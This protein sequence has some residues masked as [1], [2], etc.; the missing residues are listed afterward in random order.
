MRRQPSHGGGHWFESSSAHQPSLIARY[1][2]SYGCTMNR[3][4]LAFVVLASVICVETAEAQTTPVGRR[5]FVASHIGP[6]WDDLRSE[7]HRTQRAVVEGGVS[8]GVE[9]PTAGI[10]V[11]LSVS[12]WHVKRNEPQRFRW[13]GKTSGFL[14]HDHLYESVS[15]QRRRSPE[16]SILFRKN[17]R[18]HGAVTVTWLVGG[19]FAY[20]PEEALGI[21]SEVL[22]DGSLVEVERRGGRSTRN[23]L[24]AVAGLEATVRLSGHWAIVPRVRLTGFP[25]IR[26]DSGSAPRLVVIRPQLAVRWTF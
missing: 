1:A 14:Q 18:A 11:D 3:S 21:T 19:A 13:A 10:E 5:V 15:T 16:V 6:K 12:E 7:S 20:R 2:R 25:S 22:P 24:A 17:E 4:N 8:I 26:D 9:W 23:Y